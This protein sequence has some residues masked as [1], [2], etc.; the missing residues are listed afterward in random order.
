MLTMTDYMEYGLAK[1]ESI[2]DDRTILEQFMSLQAASSNIEKMFEF[3]SIMEFCIDNEIT[4]PSIIQEGDF[5]DAVVS[6]FENVMDWLH[7][8][9]RSIM[10]MFS[11]TTLDKLVLALNKLDNDIVMPAGVCYAADSFESV[12]SHIDEFA[13]VI[14]RIELNDG[15]KTERDQ[16]IKDLDILY[17]GKSP[18]VEKIKKN[19]VVGTSEIRTYSKNGNTW[20]ETVI[21]LKDSNGKTNKGED[22]QFSKETIIQTLTKMKTMNIPKT[23][24]ALLKKM[25]FNKSKV[26]TSDGKPDK[27]IIRLIRKNAN[28]IATMYDLIF[29]DTLKF[30]K[31][32][33]TSNNINIKELSNSVKID[34]KNN[35]FYKRNGRDQTKPLS[36]KTESL[37]KVEA[38]INKKGVN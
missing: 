1:E 31:N 10:D 11:T 15:L 33:A 26:K 34:E 20:Q 16:I 36:H 7:G 32:L 27:E 17:E 3:H 35:E 12:L 5:G 22:G 2:V 4:V 18:L 37:R 29:R 13:E 38:T 9:V 19:A 8:I 30:C 21:R 23:G 6:F 14:N 25:E 28:L 24:R